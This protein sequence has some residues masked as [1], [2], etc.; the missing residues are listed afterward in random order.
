[1]PPEAE[2][3]EYTYQKPLGF[4]NN[5]MLS[6]IILQKIK[7]TPRSV[8][9]VYVTPVYVSPIKLSKSLCHVF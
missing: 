7:S 8:K 3:G 1:M 4:N 9:I 6:D 2:L 5:S